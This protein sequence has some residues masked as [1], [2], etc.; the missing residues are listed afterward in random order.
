MIVVFSFT[1]KS[2]L[3]ILIVFFCHAAGGILV[4][5][6]GIEPTTSALEA[7]S[8]TTAFKHITFT[9]HFISIVITSAPPQ[10]LRH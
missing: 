6:P 5:P 1:Y 10:I 9:V 8:L 2:S 7:Q 4:P 3:H